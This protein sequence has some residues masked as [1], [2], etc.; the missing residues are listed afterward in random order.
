MSPHAQGPVGGNTYKMTVGMPF[1]TWN[2]DNQWQLCSHLT[3]RSDIDNQRRS[4]PKYICN[5]FESTPTFLSLSNI[6]L[7]RTVNGRKRECAVTASFRPSQPWRPSRSERRRP[8]P[9]GA[10][11]RSSG[12]T[13]HAMPAARPAALCS[14]LTRAL[15]PSSCSEPRSRSC[16][17]STTKTPS[18][19]RRR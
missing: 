9:R 18:M 8:P 14:R 12:V 11:P 4:L 5:S 19:P 7:R 13:G 1:S 17:A 6:Q 15:P 3:N 16:S 10:P 2:H